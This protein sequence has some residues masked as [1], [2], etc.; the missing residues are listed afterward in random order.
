MTLAQRVAHLTPSPTLTIAAKAKAL[1]SE[2]IDVCSFSAGEPDL[3]TP[4]HIKAAAIE[5]LQAG[6]TKYG[7][8]A[9]IPALRQAIA[10]KLQ[11]H[12]HVSY[13]PEEVMVSNGGKQT[14]YNLFMVLLDPGDEVIIPS[15]YW[16][17]YLDMTLLANG[18]PVI[19]NTDPKNTFKLTPGQLQ[20]AITPQTKL[21]I[22][23][24]P[25]NP[26][27][28]VYEPSELEALLTVIRQYS[29]Y[30]VSDEIYEH[31]TY[32]ETKQVSIR[33]LAPDLHHRLVISNGFAKS[34]SMT[35]WRIGYLAAPLPIIQAATSLQ[36]HSTSN[37]CT[38][39]QHGAV[40]ALTH[41]LS[42][43]CLAQMRGLFSQRRD[44]MLSHLQSIPGV[45]CLAP[46]GAFYMFPNI[47][48][49]GMSSL[50]FCE[51]LLE[52]YHV[53]AIPGVVFGADDYIRL[54]YATDLAT[55]EKGMD[56]LRQFI[57]SR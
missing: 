44:L 38:F 46:A 29:F 6:E 32:D 22:L 12:N 7:P 56:R 13:S 24:S 53:A 9:G 19:V 14:L 30:V 25:S 23:N 33:Q 2:G 36:S 27:G 51:Q 17:S 52:Q 11:T 4:E 57:E 41:P 47:H 8:A 48:Q 5:A 15:P 35:G 49:T 18:T 37:V 21:L 45:T 28:S 34:Y 1:K 26:T 16:V 42:P 3:D 31:L 55:I 40:A 50:D 10:Q 54:S 39:A 20:A 43:L